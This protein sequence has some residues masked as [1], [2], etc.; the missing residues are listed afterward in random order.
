VFWLRREHCGKLPRSQHFPQARGLTMNHKAS[1]TRHSSHH[2]LQSSASLSSKNH[3]AK[4]GK[5][6]KN[7]CFPRFSP[8]RP[9]FV[10][11]TVCLRLSKKRRKTELNFDNEPESCVF[12]LE[13]RNSH[14]RVIFKCFFI[15]QRRNLTCKTEFSCWKWRKSSN[16][17]FLT[18]P[19]AFFF[20][21]PLL[22]ASRSR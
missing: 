18:S 17:N 2:Q 19:G 1:G 5:F 22:R 12:L 20:L 15:T 10:Y 4:L 13:K 7:F 11:A 21:P 8:S 9:T 14:P 6:N 3:E 16:M